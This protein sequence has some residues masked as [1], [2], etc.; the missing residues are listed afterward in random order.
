M[1]GRGG[2]PAREEDGC[3]D[4]NPKSTSLRWIC[5][6]VIK[7]S[8]LALKPSGLNGER[9]LFHLKLLTSKRTEAQSAF[10]DKIYIDIYKYMTLDHDVFK[11]YPLYPQSPFATWYKN[12]ILHISFTFMVVL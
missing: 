3:G 12:D 1:R 7:R 9:E 4:K 10:R 11:T 5:E 6:E 2:G 8:R